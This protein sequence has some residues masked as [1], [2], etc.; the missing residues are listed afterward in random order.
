MESLGQVLKCNWVR[1]YHYYHYRHHLA[2]AIAII[3]III[4]ISGQAMANIR[5][6]L[7]FRVS[8]LG[9]LGCPAFSLAFVFVPSFA[10]SMKHSQKEKENNNNNN[11]RVTCASK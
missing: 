5:P 9:S 6:N 4:V 10:K 2:V 1:L 11:R 7:G 8:S 3:I